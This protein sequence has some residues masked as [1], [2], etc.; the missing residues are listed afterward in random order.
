MLNTKSAAHSQ[1]YGLCSDSLRQWVF[2][3]TE[4]QC[5]QQGQL[6]QVEH[7]YQDLSIKQRT[8][9]SY[10]SPNQAKSKNAIKI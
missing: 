7:P 9:Q 3:I 4:P 5:V 2:S 1:G 10:I 6:K 8:Q